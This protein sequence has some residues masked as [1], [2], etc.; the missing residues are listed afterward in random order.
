LIKTK[1]QVLKVLFLFFV[2]YPDASY[3]IQKTTAIKTVVQ[4]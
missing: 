3:Y 4:I 2:D 1:L